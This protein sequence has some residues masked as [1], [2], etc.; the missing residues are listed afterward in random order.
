[1]LADHEL[2]G[3]QEAIMKEGV[4]PHAAKGLR[5]RQ[6]SVR[7]ECANIVIHLSQ[8]TETKPESFKALVIPLISSLGD[9]EEQLVVR[10]LECLRVLAQNE[11]LRD[12]IVE[13]GCVSILCS[14]VV[15]EVHEMKVEVLKYASIFSHFHSCF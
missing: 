5:D 2:Q 9:D 8:H 3:V 4:L 7:K 11:M 12:H 14:Y 15:Q 1:M 10:T 13:N 6:A